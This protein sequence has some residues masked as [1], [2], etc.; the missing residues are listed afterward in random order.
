MSS[1]SQDTTEIFSLRSAV[2]NFGNSL[3]NFWEAIPDDFTARVQTAFSKGRATLNLFAKVADD[4]GRLA[5]DPLNPA[6]EAPTL[7]QTWNNVG[8]SVAETK[9]AFVSVAEALDDKRLSE[10]SA[11][12]VESGSKVAQVADSLWSAAR[13]LFEPYKGKVAE[14]FTA[15]KALLSWFGPANPVEPVNAVKATDAGKNNQPVKTDEAG[16][17]NQ[18]AAAADA[19]ENNSPAKTDDAGENNSPAKTDDAG[20]NNSPAEPAD[21]GE[22]NSPAEPTDAGENNSPAEPADAGENN[23]PAAAAD[24]GVN[25]QPA[26][27]ADA[28]EN[29]SPAEPA[30][31]GV[32]NQP[33]G[34]ADAGENNSPAEPADAGENNQPAGAADAGENNSPAEPAD[35]GEN[36]QPAAAADAGENNQPAA[37]ADAGENNSP[38]EPADAGENN[39][40]GEAAK[41]GG[42]VDASDTPKDKVERGEK[43]DDAEEDLLGDDP[44]AGADTR[45]SSAGYGGGHGG[46]FGSFLNY[47]SWTPAE[48][49]IPAASEDGQITEPP[50]VSPDS[51]FL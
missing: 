23:Q 32:N 14:V 21:A 48:N 47:F 37:A 19:G 12:L 49:S 24:A 34:A 10:A 42:A 45:D 46:W 39:Q 43:P 20:E 9:A 35:A 13:L 30:D 17:N 11:Q 4:A 51:Y 26:G 36:N 2:Q 29:N 40:P 33:A 3:K 50:Q 7:E 25:N 1:N 16:V 44:S 27:A 5:E 28:G 18:P 8:T 38:A 41:P 15:G 31:A 22:N 6:E